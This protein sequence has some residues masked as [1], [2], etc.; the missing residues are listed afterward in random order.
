MQET[1]KQNNIDNDELHHL[2]VSTA[3]LRSGASW[4]K[5]LAILMTIGSLALNA[6]GQEAEKV[7]PKTSA[8]ET[9]RALATV[10][11]AVESKV[12]LVVET[13]TP[14]TTL[15]T[16]SPKPL[17]ADVVNAQRE[18]LNAIN[19]SNRISNN[20]VLS[21]VTPTPTPVVPQTL[22]PIPQTTILL[23][24]ATQPLTNPNALDFGG[25]SLSPYGE[26]YVKK[27]FT[28]LD[29]N[30]Y[31]HIPQQATFNL[32]PFSNCQGEIAAI[33]LKLKQG[34]GILSEKT[35]P[36]LTNL[37]ASAAQNNTLQ[38][39]IT[40]ASNG[41]AP[42]SITPSYSVPTTMPTPMPTENFDTRFRRVDR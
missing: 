20:G 13:S 14:R 37:E 38:L 27:L 6:C 24:G 11:P 31:F 40:Q 7:V 30:L 26:V 34:A 5:P 19:Y 23:G 10:A 1:S 28:C 3:Q 41:L 2:F 39:T 42:Q 25:I 15:P 29:N 12:P 33:P 17:P 32:G 21:P 36:L 8:T 35:N 18:A 22:Q 16:T 9:A 4:K